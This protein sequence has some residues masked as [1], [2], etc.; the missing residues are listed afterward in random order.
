MAKSSVGS[1]LSATT[2]GP[3]IIATDGQI[4]TTSVVRYPTGPCYFLD[5]SNPR[6]KMSG[7]SD[8]LKNWLKDKGKVSW[9]PTP[10]HD[11]NLAVDPSWIKFIENWEHSKV[12]LKE[13]RHRM[14]NA[15][16][17][18]TTSTRRIFLSFKLVPNR[19]AGLITGATER[20]IENIYG[21]AEN[22]GNSM[23]SSFSATDA[24]EDFENGSVNK[25]LELAAS[26][27]YNAN[28]MDDLMSDLLIP[29]IYITSQGSAKNTA[30]NW[31]PLQ[32]YF[33]WYDYR[34]G[35]GYSVHV[36]TRYTN[37][38]RIENLGMD[39]IDVTSGSDY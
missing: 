2:S 23:P 22:N 30:G 3:S 25:I 39:D 28:Q 26:A 29:Y 6:A 4:C 11:L 21:L 7:A 37:Q 36:A 5:E 32:A 18:G 19:V 8:K 38:D 33:A 27:G 9:D 16:R 10:A 12:G 20:A 34:F 15:A 31:V 35:A 1:D 17:Y 13:W 14:D 24:L